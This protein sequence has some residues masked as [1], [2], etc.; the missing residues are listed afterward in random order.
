MYAGGEEDL[1]GVD[2]SEADNDGLIEEEGFDHSTTAQ[3]LFE[4][5]QTDVERFGPELCN[6]GPG[7]EMGFG[8]IQFEP[9]EAADI[10]EV[11][12]LITLLEFQAKVGV[13]VGTALEAGPV[14]LAG[15][16]Q[17]DG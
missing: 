11:K 15:H 5:G 3:K 2:I 7:Q 10:A 14:E 1:V 9:T 8:A 17:V 16:S 4:I 6:C 12:D 13:T